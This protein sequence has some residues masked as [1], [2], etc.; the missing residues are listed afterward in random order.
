[1]FQVYKRYSQAI[2]KERCAATSNE[3]H[4]LLNRITQNGRCSTISPDALWKSIYEFESSTMTR[5]YA[6]SVAKR[7]N[8][9]KSE[10]FG[11]GQTARS[12]SIKK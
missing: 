1:M 7:M 6:V 8:Y 10:L 12:S 2:I 11:L 9:S 3:A 5:P 4:I